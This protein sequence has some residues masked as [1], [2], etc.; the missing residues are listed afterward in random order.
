MYAVFGRSILAVLLVGACR[1][2][3]VFQCEALAECDEGRCEPTGFCSFPNSN[4]ASGWQYGD[5]ADAVHRNECV[6]GTGAPDGGVNNLLSNGTFETGIAGWEG[7]DGDVQWSD[8]SRSGD[9][10]AL[11]CAAP[12]QTSYTLGDTPNTVIGTTPGDRYRAE[13]WVRTPPGAGSI[14]VKV[15]LREAPPDADIETESS[16]IPIDETWRQVTIEHVIQTESDLSILV[17]GLAS[18]EDTC[19][20]IDDAVVE[21]L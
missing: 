8:I 14:L 3:H 6:S 10:A 12:G 2:S 20:L 11:V 17:R 15:I 19:F 5:Y 13:A 9:H 21:L 1:P 4:C 7:F 16:P 18:T